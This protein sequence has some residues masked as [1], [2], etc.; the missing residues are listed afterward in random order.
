LHR[1]DL[2]GRLTFSALLPA[3]AIP[4]RLDPPEGIEIIDRKG[5]T[6]F[7]AEGLSLLSIA[8][9]LGTG[10][11]AQILANWL[12]DQFIKPKSGKGSKKTKINERVVKIRS[13]DE[14]VELI[15]REIT[16]NEEK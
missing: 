8:I 5:I 7:D 3:S 1:I 6:Y 9:A 12:Y 4:D 16:E 10:V 2:V 14:F 11:T 15:E 13:R